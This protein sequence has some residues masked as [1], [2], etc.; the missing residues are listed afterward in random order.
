MHRYGLCQNKQPL[1]V[2]I[3]YGFV[4]KDY[5]T[6]A[7]AIGTKTSYGTKVRSTLM[8]GWWRRC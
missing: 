7:P 4:L 8:G 1:L 3:N 2:E 6:P 5:T